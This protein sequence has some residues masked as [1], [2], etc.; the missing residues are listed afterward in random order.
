MIYGKKYFIS[1]RDLMTFNEDLSNI[2]IK[3]LSTNFFRIVLKKCLC[4][5]L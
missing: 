2:L 5:V 1:V 4:D 3:L